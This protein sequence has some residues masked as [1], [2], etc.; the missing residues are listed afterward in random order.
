MSAHTL[1]ILRHAKAEYRE[2]IADIERQ[3]TARGKGDAGAAGQWLAEH[4]YHPDLVLC[5]P[6]KRTRQTWHEVAV[7][8]ADHHVQTTVKYDRKVYDGSV[9]DLMRLVKEAGDAGTVLLIGHNPVVSTLSSQLDPGASKD[10]DGLKTSG[11]AVHC[12]DSDWA[13]WEMAALTAAHTARA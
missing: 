4:G 3:L 8:L 11:I 1:V 2:D 7:A 12:A 13:V 10:T 5:S 9:A 6:A